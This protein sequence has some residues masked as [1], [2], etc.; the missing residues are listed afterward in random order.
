MPL[1][2][3]APNAGENCVQEHAR[4]A[5]GSNALKMWRYA[6]SVC[7][8]QEQATLPPRSI[9]MRRRLGSGRPQTG[10]SEYSCSLAC[11]HDLGARTS[12]LTPVPPN[13]RRSLVP[14]DR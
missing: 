2:I 4:Q 1:W 10:D 7:S 11:L 8:A 5:L 9:Q 13:L 12:S 14:E 6:V 3:I